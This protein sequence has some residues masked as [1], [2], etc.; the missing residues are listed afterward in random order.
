MLQGHTWAYAAKKT[1]ARHLP[2]VW[3]ISRVGVTNHSLAWQDICHSCCH[4]EIIWRRACPGKPASQTDGTFFEPFTIFR[5]PKLF[6]KSPC[7]GK[8]RR[9]EPVRRS[10]RGMDQLVP[11]S[12]ARCYTHAR[13]L[14]GQPAHFFHLLLRRHS[15]HPFLEDRLSGLSPLLLE[16]RPTRCAVPPATGAPS[17]LTDRR[18]R[19]LLVVPADLGLE[20][21]FGESTSSRTADFD[22]CIM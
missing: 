20:K 17:Q 16:A 22:V 3:S 9:V 8:Q 15:G 14:R 21:S 13:A 2:R 19:L 12:S 6:L 7:H 1:W 11:R 18:G 10:P 5:V 4:V